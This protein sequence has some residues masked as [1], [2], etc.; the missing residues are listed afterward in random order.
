MVRKIATSSKTTKRR[1]PPPGEGKRGEHG[2]LAYLLRQAQAAA[3]L[4]ME[5]SLADLGITTPQFV[6]LTML[7]AYPG[8]SGA[9]LA[10]VA[11]LTPQTVGVIIRNLERDG[12]IRKTPHPVHG[13]VLQ[14][15]V[16]KRGA[17]LLDK[18]RRHALTIER[19]L[20]AGLSTQAQATIRRWLARIA[21]EL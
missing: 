19:R 7:K 6:V 5:R 17:A 3:R 8:L 21:R 11:L 14:W 1:P 2:Y 16:T 18:C 10:R 12:A 9:D 20:V 15:T 4:T 13:R